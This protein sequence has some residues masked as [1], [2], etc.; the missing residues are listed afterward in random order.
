MKKQPVSVPEFEF[1]NGAMS[2]AQCRRLTEAFLWG[3]D[4]ADQGDRAAR[5]QRFLVEWY[6]PEHHR[7][8][9]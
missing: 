1:Y 4:A 9:R 3:D 5:R 6:P 7:G 2:T 8:G